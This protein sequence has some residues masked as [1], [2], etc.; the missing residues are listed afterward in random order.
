L[1]KKF[2]KGNSM[3][4]AEGIPPHL[5]AEARSMWQRLNDDFHLG[6]A[7]GRALLQAACESFDRA[8]QARRRID[9]EGAL[10][11][12]RFGQ[13]KPH[14]LCAVERDARAQMIGALRAL[15]LAPGE[16]SE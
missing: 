5:S 7:A 1:G 9:R 12:D 10:I 11:H 2:S 4:K 16:E 14:P 8:Q 6:D 13:P 3:K 15:R